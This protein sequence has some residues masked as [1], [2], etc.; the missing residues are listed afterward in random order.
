M[1]TS[2]NQ[3]KGNCPVCRKDFDAQD[4]EHVLDYMDM[5]SS[6][7]NFAGMV[8]DEDEK[9]ILQSDE[10]SL[11]REKFEA[12]LKLQQENN[13]LIEPRKNLAILPGM[14]LPENI[15]VPTSSAETIGIPTTSAET[16][17]VQRGDPNQQK[18]STK[19]SI[20]SGTS[21]HNNSYRRRNNRFHSSKGPASAPHN[22]KQWIK[23]DMDPSEQ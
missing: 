9:V 21:K 14:F 22:R 7:L 17:S 6:T 12:L 11:R 4:M 5:N 19:S 2:I 3:Q 15:S 10:E 16:I 23:K 13:G 18:D 1:H 8:I 20:K